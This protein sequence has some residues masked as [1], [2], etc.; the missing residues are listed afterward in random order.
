MAIRYITLRISW[1]KVLSA[2]LS[3]IGAGF[4]ILPF[5]VSQTNVLTG[6]LLLAIVAIVLAVKIEDA[7]ETI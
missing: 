7:L 6:S 1:L 3:N 4:L 2:V 5:T